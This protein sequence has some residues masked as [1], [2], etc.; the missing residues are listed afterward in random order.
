[1]LTHSLTWPRY[2]SI[3][4]CYLYRLLRPEFVKT[5]PTPLRSDAFSRWN[6]ENIDEYNEAVCEATCR[7]EEEAVP[8]FAD[9]LNGHYSGDAFPA[10]AQLRHEFGNLVHMLHSRGINVRYLS[11]I[12]AYLTRPEVDRF[13]V[14]EMVARVC[15]HI[16]RS[17]MRSVRSSDEQAYRDVVVEFF[18]LLFDG[19][20]SCATYWASGLRNSVLKRFLLDALTLEER[21]PRF[22]LRDKVYMFALFQRLQDLCGVAFRAELNSI[23]HFVYHRAGASE[24]LLHDADLEHLYAIEKSIHHIDFAEGTALSFQA[25][26][27]ELGSE[28]LYELADTRFQTALTKKPDDYRTLHNWGL[29]LSHRA[30]RSDNADEAGK[31]YRL[32]ESKFQQALLINPRDYFA[33]YLWGNMQSE[34]AL[35]TKNSAAAAKLLQSAREKYALA[36]ERRPTN[37]DLCYNWGNACLH[38]SKLVASHTVASQLL[39]EACEHYRRAT[40]IQ[41]NSLRAMKNWAVTL[42]KMARTKT[43]RAEADEAFQLAEAKIKL[44]L[45]LA[46][47]DA[48]LHFNWG[49]ILYHRAR[50]YVAQRPSSSS[51]SSA[52]P[53]STQ[54]SRAS[55]AAHE[56]DRKIAFQV[57]RTLSLKPNRNS[58]AH[59]LTHRLLA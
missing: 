49:N 35:Q 45:E 58:I 6:I 8:Q 40:E 56:A 32:A 15:K 41:P 19:R 34:R 24:P 51:S 33:Y 17:R 23:E 28:R 43:N 48:E 3:K 22:D 5:S 7:L 11:L 21:S 37:V 39:Q 14:T 10:E 18:N 13:V 54:S 36:H 16:L 50:L 20:A 42:S 31:L 26:Q 2:N 38:H 46:P 52:S 55:R 59:L 57:R 44:C 12:R 4:G 53:S 47:G 30:H 1:M 27:V 25:T 29:S 9:W